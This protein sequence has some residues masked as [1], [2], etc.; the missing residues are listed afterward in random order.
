MELIKRSTT[1]RIQMSCGINPYAAGS[2]IIEFG[3]TKVHVTATVEETVPLFKK[4]F[5]EG[6]VTAEYA[7][8]PGSTGTRVKRDR[9]GISGRSQEIQR[10]IGRGLRSVVDLKL[11]GE[12]SLLID[13]DVLVADGGTR[14]ASLTG[15]YVAMELAVRNLMKNGLITKSPLIDQVAAVSIGIDSEGKIIADLNYLED[16]TCCTDMNLVMTKKGKF[17]EIQGAAEGMPFGRA[18]LNALIECGEKAFK[19][20]FAC[21]DEVL[22]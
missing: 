6:W 9:K 19:Q 4:G 15:G 21:Q 10:F 7:M 16:S 14:T 13:C 17:V 2:V 3:Q 22:K 20:V 1:R 5:G 18:E 11:L 12:R 8:L